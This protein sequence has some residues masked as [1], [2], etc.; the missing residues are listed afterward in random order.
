MIASLAVLLLTAPACS[1]P[2]PAVADPDPSTA[3]AANPEMDPSP[4]APEALVPGATDWQ[5]LA[6]SDTY[7]VTCQ[8][9]DQLVSLGDPIPDIA[10]GLEGVMYNSEPLSDCSGMFHLVLERIE[11]QCPNHDVPEPSEA[12]DTRDLAGWYHERGELILVD[13]ALAMAELIKPG[14]VIFYGH[15]A[16]RY[17]NFTAEDL[18]GTPEKKGYI[19]HM[20]VVVNVERDEAGTITNYH[21]FHGRSTGKPSKITTWHVREKK[22]VHPPYGNGNQQWVAVA[23][24]IGPGTRTA[25]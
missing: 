12:R 24:I 5:A 13:D 4:D 22:P 7:E 11:Q 9:N 15:N 21:L 18:I 8:N 20:G 16:K 10:K 23:R 3:D 19:E 6:A 25:P 14:A 1:T 17:E 2:E